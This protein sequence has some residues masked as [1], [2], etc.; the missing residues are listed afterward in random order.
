M[1]DKICESQDL[2]ADYEESYKISM[3][4]KPGLQLEKKMAN[5]KNVRDVLAKQLY[6]WVVQVYANLDN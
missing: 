4:A 1:I 2:C 6:T 3:A 5:E